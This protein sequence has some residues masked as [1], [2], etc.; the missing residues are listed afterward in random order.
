MNPWFWFCLWIMTQ[1][2]V[3]SKDDK[4]CYNRKE[5]KIMMIILF[6]SIGYIVIG[7]LI[8]ILMTIV[9]AN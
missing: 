1:E 6:A 5:R 8:L 3:S 2:P 4:V 7:L 9:F